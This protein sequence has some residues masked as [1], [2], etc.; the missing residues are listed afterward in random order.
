[1]LEDDARTEKRNP[2]SLMKVRAPLLCLGAILLGFSFLAGCGSSPETNHDDVAATETTTRRRAKTPSINTRLQKKI[3][4]EPIEQKPAP[5]QS[6]R[7]RPPQ[8][9]SIQPARIDPTALQKAGIRRLAGKH[10]VLY[11]DLPSSPAVDELPGVFDQAFGQWCDYFGL[12][13]AA[14]DDWRVTGFLIK[15]KALFGRLNLMP[16]GDPPFLHGYSQGD[17]LWLYEQPSDYYRRHL[18]LHE[19]T[20]SFM[21]MLLGG[22]GPPWYM[23]GVAELLGTHRL[24]NGKL[25]LN[26]FPAARLEAPL[27]NRTKIVADAVAAGRQRSFEE[28]L[29]YGPRAHL[30]KE[31]Y[32]W[33]WT[34][35]VLLDRHPRYRDRFRQLHKNVLGS[36]FNERFRRLIG[37]DWAD[38][39]AQWQAFV[40]ELEFGHDVARTTIRLRPAEALAAG[41]KTV[42]VEADRGWQNSGIELKAG[43]KYKLTARGRYQVADKP[44]IW[45]CEP[46]GITI[47]YY[48]G[49]PL[50]ILLATVYPHQTGDGR[51]P[52]Q[53]PITVGLGTTIT[54]RADGV[55]LFKINDSPAELHD[56]AGQLQVR[57]EPAGGGGGLTD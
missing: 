26:Y 10:L 44:R 18:L 40:A 20:H 34:A 38:M 39:T 55:L 14:H 42:R 22:S 52:F 46:G 9:A 43:R 36:D 3:D 45:W 4:K 7:K 57:I 5:R 41:G 25:S 21:D 27:W 28:V 24:K 48:R 33:S 30:D 6:T 37:D 56:N 49:R 17:R 1:M 53:Q 50:G 23:E 11:T 12:D 8:R 29:S 15:D 54:P 19:G 31:P 35:A 2:Y 47:R 32:G 16:V 13:A 51:N